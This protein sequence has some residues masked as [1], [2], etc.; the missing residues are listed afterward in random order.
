MNGFKG[1]EQLWKVVLFYCLLP[2]SILY[3]IKYAITVNV[4]AIIF[5]CVAFIVWSIVNIVALWRCAFNVKHKAI[6]YLA[7][8]G[9]LP[10]AAI[11]VT[12]LLNLILT[13]QA[14]SIHGPPPN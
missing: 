11:L 12:S 1:K 8:F 2:G 7:R 4:T 10:I 5:I 3:L 13:I 6:G 9:T 14:L